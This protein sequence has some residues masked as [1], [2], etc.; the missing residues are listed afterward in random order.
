MLLHYSFKATVIDR[1]SY[2]AWMHETK[3]NF[4]F[5]TM[6]SQLFFVNE[7]LAKT[8]TTAVDNTT[9]FC[10]KFYEVLKIKL[11]ALTPKNQKKLE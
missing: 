3:N 10:W 4:P 8:Q 7:V 6:A 5:Q 1:K 11:M 2:I 9:L